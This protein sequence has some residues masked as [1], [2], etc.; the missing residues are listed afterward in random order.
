MGELQIEG[1]YPLGYIRLLTPFFNVTGGFALV[2]G[3]VYSAYVF[4]P[5]RRVIAYDLRTDAGVG[6]FLGNLAISPIAIVVNL[7]ASIPGTVTAL[8]GGRL[9]E[10]VPATALIA[11]GGLIP[12]ITSGANR[13]GETGMF[14]LGEF[15]GVVFLFAGFAVSAVVIDDIRI[16]FT[17]IVLF[18]RSSGA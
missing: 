3:A 2:L 6:T 1:I 18:R 5:K 14:Y 17:S 11:L 7:V 15:L 4:M 16:P 8:L 9:D 10:R 12:S 13:F